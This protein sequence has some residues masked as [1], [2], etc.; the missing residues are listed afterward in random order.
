MLIRAPQNRVRGSV[1]SVLCTLSALFS[2]APAHAIA[3]AES[4]GQLFFDGFSQPPESASTLTDTD[5]FTFSSQGAAAAEADAEAVFPDGETLGGSP[6]FGFN[7]IFSEAFVDG[8]GAADAFSE[9]SVVGDFFIDGSRTTPVAFSFDFFAS[10]SVFGQV[11]SPATEQASASASIVWAVVEQSGGQINI[12]DAFDLSASLD[13]VSDGDFLVL[14]T[15]PN[16]DLSAALP[17][18]EDDFGG[19]TESADA[20]VLGRYQ[21]SFDEPQSL[22]LVEFKQGQASATGVPEPSTILAS[23]GLGLVI[24]RRS[25]QR[26]AAAATEPR[27]S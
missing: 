26:R 22:Q 23:V 4:Q 2:A 16:I 19:S 11:D 3:F 10:L 18:L 27:E 21:R 14:E 25:R 8:I 9:A 24:L 13:T 12:L 15:T 20:L 5:T 1:F 17:L 6:A 7:T